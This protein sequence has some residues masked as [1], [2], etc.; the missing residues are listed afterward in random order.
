MRRSKPS[1]NFGKGNVLGI[2]IPFAAK[3]TLTD[4]EELAKNDKLEQFLSERGV[5]NFAEGQPPV[6]LKFGQRPAF[7]RSMFDF[8][9]YSKAIERE[10]KKS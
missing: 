5:E 4:I 7:D 8:E 3:L 9:A 6:P 1:K 10:F 2:S